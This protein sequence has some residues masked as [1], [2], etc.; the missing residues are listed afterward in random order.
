MGTVDGYFVERLAI[1]VTSDGGGV[2]VVL[3]WIFLVGLLG[4]IL[5]AVVARLVLE[6]AVEYCY[7]VSD[8]S[9]S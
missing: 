6:V 5:E 1:F 9:I 7:R 2:V 8:R 4:G 3:S